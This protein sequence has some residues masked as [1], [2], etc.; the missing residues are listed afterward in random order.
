MYSSK[1]VYSYVNKYII[2]IR[3]NNF[4]QINIQVLVYRLTLQVNV[5]SNVN[6]YI[7]LICI[8]NFEQINIQVLEIGKIL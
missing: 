8:N 1:N 5:Y 2:L 3:I 7:I 4:E 6:K